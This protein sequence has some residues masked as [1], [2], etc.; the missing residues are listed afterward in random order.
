VRSDV[1]AG[2]AL[3]A[4]TALISGVSVWVNAFGVTRV[5]DA[6]LYTTLK[7]G[8]AATVLLVALLIA[9]RRRPRMAIVRP[10]PARLAALVAV[11]LLGGGLAF[12]LFFSG[13]AQGTATGAAFI[14]KTLFVW[15]ALLAVP[16]L[17]ERLGLAQLGALVV[18]LVGQV[19]LAPPRPGGWGSAETLVLLA[20]LIWAAEVIVASR[21]LAA[22]PVLL[23]GVAR[24]GIGLVVLVGAVV[25]GGRLGG[26]AAIGAQ[27]WALVVLTGLLLAGY[28]ATWFA[29]LQRAPAALVSSILVGG[30]IVTATLQAVTSGRA[31][32]AAAVA[33]GVL[34]LAA[35]GL[36]VVVAVA[37]RPA[38]A[39]GD[40]G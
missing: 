37:R 22:M 29:A 21:L 25:A 18:L 35:T 17:G 32:E 13:L 9:A 16:F 4:V 12:V 5:P 40:A 26:L 19:L 14:Q 36:L 24:L 38:V 33:G 10:S 6:I 23:L 39:S 27:G 20:T 7:N 11:G 34:I 3:A 28:V 8:V 15:V 2:A 1:R 30:A 31:P